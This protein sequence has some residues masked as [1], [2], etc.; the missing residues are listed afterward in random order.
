MVAVN[1]QVGVLYM[2][3]IDQR[4]ESDRIKLYDSEHRYFD[5]LPL[6]NIAQ[7]AIGSYCKNV[8]A[9]L[10][11]LETI[12]KILAF[13]WIRAYTVSES[14]IDLLEDIYGLDG[15]EYDLDNDRFVKLP[16]GEIL[17]EEVIAKNDFVNKIG[18]T[19]VLNCE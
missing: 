16:D 9:Q 11:K 14:W 1:T 6:E 5:Y 2:E 18:N 8:I 19:Y 17:T 10:E 3:E 7:E 13:L 4:E 15:Y 12:D